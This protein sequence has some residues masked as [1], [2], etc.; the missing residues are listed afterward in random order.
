VIAMHDLIVAA[1]LLTFLIALA[2]AAPI[3]GVD[4]RDLVDS[5]EPARRVLWLYRR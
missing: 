1:T 2:I 3:W 5:P 4:S